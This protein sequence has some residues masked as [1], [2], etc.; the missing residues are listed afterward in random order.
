MTNRDEIPPWPRPDE[1][2]TTPL[3]YVVR[4]K[5]N[6]EQLARLNYQNQGLVVYLPLMQTLRRHARRTEEVRRPVFPSLSIEIIDFLKFQA[7]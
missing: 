2:D 6:Q 5:P 7:L 1:A 3:W 4:T